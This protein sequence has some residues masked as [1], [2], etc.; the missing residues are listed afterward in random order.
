MQEEE[1]DTATQDLDEASP[2]TPPGEGMPSEKDASE[3]LPGIPDE[4]EEQRL[5]RGDE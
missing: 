1:Q 4:A 5:E 2:S 3:S